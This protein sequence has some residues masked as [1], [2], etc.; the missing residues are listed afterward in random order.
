MAAPQPDFVKIV[1][2]MQSIADGLNTVMY[3]NQNL[4]LPVDIHGQLLIIT[5]SLQRLAV[6]LA[7]HATLA[8]NQNATATLNSIS[9][10]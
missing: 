8:S 2:A 6:N 9:M 5:E 4:L 7:N 1:A 3:E 10:L